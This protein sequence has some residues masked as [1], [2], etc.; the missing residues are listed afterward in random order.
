MNYYE[1]MLN[2]YE[3]II[4][5]QANKLRSCIVKK[6]I[7]NFQS[8]KRNS[9]MMQSSLDSGLENIWDEIC[10]QT[11]TE[12][13]CYWFAYEDYIRSIIASL[14]KEMF[15]DNE[16]MIL[17]LQTN[18]C[19]EWISHYYDDDLSEDFCKYKEPDDYSFNDIIDLI[20]EDII[21]TAAN[22]NNDRIDEYLEQGSDSF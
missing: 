11:Q 18:Q 10:V 4:S 9:N 12:Y 2:F 20:F 15:D 14:L 17:W 13:S 19:T 21:D 1:G 16:L 22:Y 6:C 8:C 3:N 7:E 5:K